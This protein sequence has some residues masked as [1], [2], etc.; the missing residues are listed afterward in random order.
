MEA[1]ERDD[2]KKEEPTEIKEGRKRGQGERE[3]KMIFFLK[4]CTNVMINL[5]ITGTCHLECVRY[6]KYI[7]WVNI[8]LK[9]I[10]FLK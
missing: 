6:L 1:G 7:K 9:N 2:G 3:E 8:L 4:W 10:F 5:E